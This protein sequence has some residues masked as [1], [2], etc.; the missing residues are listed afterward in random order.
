MSGL[1]TF[2][3]N[4]LFRRQ[5]ARLH[6]ALGIPPGYARDRDLPLQPEARTLESVGRDIYRREQRLIPPAAA[7]WH[8]MTAAAAADGIE[9]QLVS[10]FRSVAYQEGILR[11]KREKGQP[12]AEILSASAAPGYSEHHSGRAVDLTA[13]GCSVLEEDFE[14]SEAFA[15]LH[16]RAGEF[17][18]SLSYPRDNPHGVIYE[19]WH[20]AW[21]GDNGTR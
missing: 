14:G 13:P 3:R 18:F 21:W 6:R 7:A 10:A 19:P 9:L 16:R 8:S 4:W 1:P 12:I 11:R 2:L 15:W 5:V 20:W 17:G